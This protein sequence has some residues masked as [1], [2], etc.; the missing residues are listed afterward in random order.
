L[1]IF[2]DTNILFDASE[3]NS[4]G[5]RLKTLLTHAINDN[6]ILT[7]SLTV[8][9]E[10]IQ[11]CMRDNKDD[12]LHNILGVIR[13]LDVQC[14]LPD[15]QLRN[16]C[17]C[18]DKVDKDH[19]VDLSDRTHLAYSISNGDDYLLTSDGAFL[20]F[21]IQKCKCRRCKRRSDN[22]LSII[23]PDQLRNLL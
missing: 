1:N 7:T 21:P 8:H 12:D 16:C 23:S 9:G 5:T 13:E 20:H 17:K 15:P 19:R 6:H 22:M 14:W 11:V 2:L 18:L 10:V 3:E 4:A